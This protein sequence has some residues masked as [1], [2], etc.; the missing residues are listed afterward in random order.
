METNKEPIRQIVVSP[1][2]LI[3]MVL[4]HPDHPANNEEEEGDGSCGS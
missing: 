2:E 3:T 4:T 1:F